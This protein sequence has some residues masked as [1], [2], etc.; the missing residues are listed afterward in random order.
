LRKVALPT[1]QP[2][3]LAQLGY[4]SPQEMSIALPTPDISKTTLAHGADVVLTTLSLALYRVDTTQVCL[5]VP[6]RVLEGQ[7][8]RTIEKYS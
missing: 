6:M 4:F 5:L 2:L 1:A 8:T 3:H 7:T